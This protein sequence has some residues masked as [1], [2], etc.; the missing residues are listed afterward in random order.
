MLYQALHD[1][2][3]LLVNVFIPLEVP[4]A[5][6]TIV[7]C[8][9]QSILSLNCH[10]VDKIRPKE[11]LIE[12]GECHPAIACALNRFHISPRE[13]FASDPGDDVPYLFLID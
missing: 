1:Q 11:M 8:V 3:L 4:A 13:V 2:M 7:D 5:L 6:L 12:P 9:L 10:V